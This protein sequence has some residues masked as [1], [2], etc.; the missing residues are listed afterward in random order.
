[1]VDD[2][3][4]SD[5]STDSTDSSVSINWVGGIMHEYDVVFTDRKTK[6]IRNDLCWGVRDGKVVHKTVDLT[7]NDDNDHPSCPSSPLS[8]SSVEFVQVTPPI[9]TESVVY[10]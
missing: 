7:E 10:E 8:Q 4:C 2:G 5:C 9:S 1:M 3:D 6:Q